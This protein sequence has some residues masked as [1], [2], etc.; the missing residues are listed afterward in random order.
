MGTAYVVGVCQAFLGHV[1]EASTSVAALSFVL[2]LPVYMLYQ[3][4]KG[5]TDTLWHVLTV[6]T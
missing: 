6:R 3:F 1:D 5:F 2:Q 4:T